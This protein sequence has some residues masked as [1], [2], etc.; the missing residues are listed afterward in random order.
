MTTPD[1]GIVCLDWDIVDTGSPS[2]AIPSASELQEILSGP[3]VALPN[4]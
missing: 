3:S 2:S 4:N 1:G